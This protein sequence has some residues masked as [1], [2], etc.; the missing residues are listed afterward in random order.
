MDLRLGS[1]DGEREQLLERD[2]DLLCLQR[3]SLGERERDLLRLELR[4]FDPRRMKVL[5][6]WAS[7]S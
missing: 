3:D 7:V 4:F 1:G 6:G 2:L 5:S